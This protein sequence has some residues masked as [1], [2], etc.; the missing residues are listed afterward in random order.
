MILLDN[1]KDKSEAKQA[2]IQ[3]ELERM[4][5]TEEEFATNKSLQ[6]KLSQKFERGYKK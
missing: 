1:L 4:K 3:I 2:F 6:K 5:V